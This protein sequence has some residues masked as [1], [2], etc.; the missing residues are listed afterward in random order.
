MSLILDAG[1]EQEVFDPLFTYGK[2]G[3]ES[4]DVEILETSKGKE[5]TSG[6]VAGV[7]PTAPAKAIIAKAIGIEV[8]PLRFPQVI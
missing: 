5:E 2:G 4:G 6:P 1:K 7:S 8:A 3:D